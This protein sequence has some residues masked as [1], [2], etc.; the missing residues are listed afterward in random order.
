VGSTGLRRSGSILW[1]SEPTM[2]SMMFTYTG[3]RTWG[4]RNHRQGARV[5]VVV[6]NAFKTQYLMPVGHN[7]RFDVK[8]MKRP[9]GG[10][11]VLTSGWRRHCTGVQPFLPPPLLQLLWCP[12]HSPDC[13]CIVFKSSS[14]PSTLR[15]SRLFLSQFF[16]IF[17]PVRCRWFICAT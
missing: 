7:S 8:L 16:S 4:A 3:G 14:K 13:T 9:A 15:S 1:V 12:A 10:I 6:Y 2:A 17:P 11:H 5:F